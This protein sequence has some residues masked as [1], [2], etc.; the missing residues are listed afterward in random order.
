MSRRRRD[1]CTIASCCCLLDRAE[2]VIS[3]VFSPNFYFYHSQTND[4]RA[5]P[6]KI[7]LFNFTTQSNEFSHLFSVCFFLPCCC[8]C[9]VCF[10]FTDLCALDGS[11][12]I[13]D[14]HITHNE[15]QKRGRFDD[16]RHEIDLNLNKCCGL[17]FFFFCCCFFIRLLVRKTM[18]IVT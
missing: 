9:C 17:L 10:N 14:T 18:S 4:D 3:R 6:Q 11:P 16:R 15:H 8:C 7:Y 1:G 12:V 5:R 13:S 2:S